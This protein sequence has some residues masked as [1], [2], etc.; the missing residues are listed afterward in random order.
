MH[1]YKVTIVKI[2]DGDTIDVDIDLGFGVWLRG[3]RVRLSNI[4]TP[5]SRTRNKIEKLFGKASANRVKEFF[6]TEGDIIMM[7]REFKKGKYGR[8]MAD[9]KVQEEVRPLCT[10]LIQEGYAVPY[11]G[12]SKESIKQD[13]L[14]NRNRLVFE[15]KVIIPEELLEEYNG[16]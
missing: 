11:H 1:E 10:T 16:Q 15:K 12:Q 3:E 6:D 9:F 7:S 5:E 4:D 14:A 13:H 2:V 8:I